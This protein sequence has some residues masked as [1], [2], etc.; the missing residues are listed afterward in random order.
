[1][2]LKVFS[3]TEGCTQLL[4]GA[5]GA[6]VRLAKNNQLKKYRLQSEGRM[7]EVEM[8]WIAGEYKVRTMLNR[9]EDAG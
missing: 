7:K 9:V 6:I 2:L 3:H 5:F 8:Q 4:K 1:M